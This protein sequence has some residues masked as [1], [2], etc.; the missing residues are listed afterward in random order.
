MRGV[1]LLLACL[2]GAGAA[3]AAPAR[4]GE[5]DKLI[6]AANRAKAEGRFDESRRLWRALWDAEGEP[7]AACNIGQLSSRMEDP[8]TAVEFLTI[9]VERTPEAQAHRIELA[10][11]EAHVG[12]LSVR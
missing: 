4:Q 9:C 12:R 6:E 11:A 8:V 2:L 7:V 10:R 1:F 5:R 3:H